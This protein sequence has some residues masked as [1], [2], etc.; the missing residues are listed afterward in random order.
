MAVGPWQSVGS[1]RLSTARRPGGEARPS[2]GDVVSARVWRLLASTV[3]GSGPTHRRR[4][5]GHRGHPGG[6]GD[7]RVR[8]RGLVRRWAAGLGV[9]GHAAGPVPGRGDAGR[10]RP[11]RRRGPGL[12]GRHGT[13]QRRGLH[14]GARGTRGIRRVQGKVLPAHDGRQRG[15][16]RGGLGCSADPLGRRRRSQGTWPIG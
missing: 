8:R 6:G 7:R 4:H 2:D 3:A 1:G 15:R 12:D 11:V 16:R 9:R 5:P 14:C 10:P 13:R